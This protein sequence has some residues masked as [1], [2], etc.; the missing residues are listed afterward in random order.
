MPHAGN[1][2]ENVTMLIDYKSVSVTHIFN[3]YIIAHY[4][5]HHVVPGSK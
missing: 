2:V 4:I 5:E 1:V 3:G